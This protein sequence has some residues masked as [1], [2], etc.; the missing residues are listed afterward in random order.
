MNNFYCFQ[1]HEKLKND[2]EDLKKEVGRTK[3]DRDDKFK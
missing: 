3:K 1:H 2:H